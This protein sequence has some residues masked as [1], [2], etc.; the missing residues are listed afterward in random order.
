[1]VPVVGMVQGA[2]FAVR[3]SS[4]VHPLVCALSCASPGLS[5][6]IERGEE[7]SLEPSE[8]VKVLHLVFDRFDQLADTFKVQKVRKTVNEYYMV[9]AGL[10]D[11]EVLVG[12]R[13][14]AMAITALAFSMVQVT[15]AGIFSRLLTPSH[16]LSHAF[17]R[18]RSPSRGCR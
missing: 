15:D 6:L 18:V 13:E 11:P 8:V 10:P 17:P 5:D 3:A 14:R 12:I 2:M 1:M 16:A 7:G 9:A 4:Q